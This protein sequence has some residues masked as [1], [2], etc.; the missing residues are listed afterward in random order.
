MDAHSVTKHTPEEVPC[1]HNSE[2]TQEALASDQHWQLPVPRYLRELYTWAYIAPFAHWLFDRQWIVSLI[3]WFNDKRLMRSV[4]AEISSGD[5]VY[6]PASV[7]GHFCPDLARKA[8]PGPVTISDISTVQ[9]LGQRKKCRKYNLKNLFIRRAN[10]A[11]PIVGPYDVAISFLLLHEVPEDY[12]HAIVNRLLDEVDLG[13]K[14]IFVDYH[15]MAWWHPLWPIM[16]FIA[17]WLEPYTFTL[18]KNEIQDYATK[19][20]QAQFTWEKTTCFG[21]LYQKIIAKR[22]APRP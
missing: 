22:I 14:A 6:M 2:A 16:A 1:A 7:Y 8:N 12:K 20:R 15:K 19:G 10:A 5:R 4:L 9:L 3:L 18:W 13:G 11:D 21:G 17:W